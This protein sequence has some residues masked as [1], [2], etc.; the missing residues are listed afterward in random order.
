MSRGLGFGMWIS[1]F[2]CGELRGLFGPGAG[3]GFR[4]FTLRLRSGQAAPNSERDPRSPNGFATL[5][6][7]SG[8]VASP[9]E[10]FG[11]KGA[12]STE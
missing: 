6:V 8:Q 2:V 3:E 9:A 10:G 7:C 11:V 4:R 5:S 12:E 1:G